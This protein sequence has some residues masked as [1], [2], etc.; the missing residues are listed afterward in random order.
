MAVV[1]MCSWSQ[2]YDRRC[3]T[4]GFRN[5]V[6]LKIYH[7]E[8]LKHILGSVEVQS[9]PFSV[10]WKFGEEDANLDVVLVIYNASKLQGQSPIAL[11][12]L[13]NVM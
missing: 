6:S 3:Q 1:G 7:V 4:E 9:S 10:V 5:P 2:T 8:G 13:L 12:L 11:V